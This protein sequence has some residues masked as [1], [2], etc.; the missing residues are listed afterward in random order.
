MTSPQQAKVPGVFTLNPNR[1]LTKTPGVFAIKPNRPLTTTERYTL[2]H[3]RLSDKFKCYVGVYV[4]NQ[5]VAA[6][7]DSGNTS[8]SCMNSDFAKTLGIPAD[9]IHEPIIPSVRIANND[10][11]ICEGITILHIVLSYQHGLA[12]V[13]PVLILK[14][15][16]HDLNIGGV[17][18][19]EHN[20]DLIYTEGVMRVNKYWKI[21]LHN[22][23]DLGRP[24]KKQVSRKPSHKN[25]AIVSKGHQKLA[26]RSVNVIEAKAI[27][28]ED[29]HQYTDQFIPNAKFEISEFFI[30]QH[31]NAN[32][33]HWAA[34]E[35]MD[36]RVPPSVSIRTDNEVD[37]F[38]TNPYQHDIYISDNAHMGSA[39][40]IERQQ[41][42]K[43]SH[44]S[45]SK[46]LSHVKQI[47]NT[48]RNNIQ[49]AVNTI[50]PHAKQNKQTEQ[51]RKPKEKQI[52][53]VTGKKP[54][55]FHQQ[56]GTMEEQLKA[57]YGTEVIGNKPNAEL[58]VDTANK[59][60]K[61]VVELFNFKDSK[62]LSTDKDVR[63]QVAKLCYHYW[64]IH[65]RDGNLG[66]TN[67]VTY[68]IN[69]PRNVAPIRLKS[70]PVNPNMQDAL[71][72]QIQKWLQ[73]DVICACSS[74]PWNSPLLP[75]VKK[76]GSIRYALDF[77]QLNKITKKS[78]FPLP[79]IEEILS[80]LY[81]SKI[82]S[83]I[84]LS[85]A[86]HAIPIR[87][88]DQEKT[89]FT[90]NDK[91]YKFKRLPFGLCNSPSIYSELMTIV[92]KPF[93]K[94]E[95]VHFMDDILVYSKTVTE[96]IAT[97]KRLF[98]AF[99][100]AGMRIT[101]QKTELLRSEV[102]YLGHMIGK[103]GMKI[104]KYYTDIITTW[105]LPQ[106]LKQL[107]MFMGKIG[108]YRKFIDSFSK[109]ASPL[110]DHMKITNEGK[111][112]LGLQND[113]KAVSSFNQLK[114]A[115]ANATTLTIPD[116]SPGTQFILDT[117]FSSLGISCVLSQKQ[118]PEK[119]ERPIAFA[120]KRLLANE[121][122]YS[123]T[124]GELLAL[125]Y[126]VK[127]FKFYLTCSKFLWRTDNTSLTHI[128]TMQP[129]ANLEARWLE[130][131]ASFD[132]EI[133][134]RKGTQHTN[135]DVLSRIEHSPFLTEKESKDLHTAPGLYAIKKKKKTKT[136][137]VTFRPPLT[138][139]DLLLQ[140][141]DQSRNSIATRVKLARRA[142]TAERETADQ[143]DSSTTSEEQSLP[144]VEQHSSNEA[145]LNV[146]DLK[147]NDATVQH[148]ARL[149]PVHDSSSTDS[150]D[151]KEEEGIDELLKSKETITA[152]QKSPRLV[153]MLYAQQNDDELQQVR[154]W[155][156]LKTRPQGALLKLFSRNLK[157]YANIYE[158]LQID[159]N[160][161]LCKRDPDYN[162][163][164]ICVPENL[165][166]QIIEDIHN[167]AHIGETATIWAV[168]SRYYF[169]A[170]TVKV[171][172][173]VTTCLRCQRKKKKKGTQRH[174]YEVDAYTV[175]FTSV[176]IDHVGPL[177]ATPEGLRFL[178]VVLDRATRWVEAY[179]VKDLSALTTAKTLIDHYF[180]RFGFP[181]IVHSDNSK[182]FVGQVF[183]EAMR[184]L[185]IKTTTTPVYNPCSN[186]VERANG[187]LGCKLKA[188]VHETNKNWLE[189]LP[190]ALLAIRSSVNRSTGFSPF[191]L[192]FGQRMTLPIDIAYSAAPSTFYGTR[193]AVR[194]LLETYQKMYKIVREKLLLQ[195]ERSQEDYNFSEDALHVGTLVWLFT[196][197]GDP[198]FGRKL[199]NYWAGPFSITA[200]V[201]Q[202]LYK[203]KTYGNWSTEELETTVAADRLRICHV[204]DEFL[205]EGRP[206]ALTINDI[207]PYNE[208]D[209][210]L[211]MIPIS[212]LAPHIRWDDP[213]LMN[214]ND[215]MQHYV[216]SNAGNTANTTHYANDRQ[217][218]IYPSR[219][220]HSK[221]A[222][223]PLISKNEENN[224]SYTQSYNYPQNQDQNDDG[225][226][227]KTEA[228]GNDNT[229]LI[230]N[231]NPADTAIVQRPSKI[232]TMVNASQ[233]LPPKYSS[234]R[235][236]N[237]S[238]NDVHDNTPQA[239]QKPA[240]P[241]PKPAVQQTKPAVPQPKPN[242]TGANK[243]PIT[244]ENV[245]RRKSDLKPPVRFTY[246]ADH[247]A[248]Q[249]RKG[250]TGKQKGIL[251][252]AAKEQTTTKDSTS[253]D[254]PAANAQTTNNEQTA[255]QPAQSQDTSQ[256]HDDTLGRKE[257][258]LKAM[259]AN[260]EQQ[261]NI[262][263]SMAQM[264]NIQEAVSQIPQVHV[265]E[266]GH[267]PP[268]GSRGGQSQSNLPV[269]NTQQ[270]DGARAMDPNITAATAKRKQQRKCGRCTINFTCRNCCEKCN[271]QRKQYC[272]THCMSGCTDRNTCRKHR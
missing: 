192:L 14:G 148:T 22:K 260:M 86:F 271:V 76:N 186:P 215:S 232:Q 101:P 136:K 29:P 155:V 120:S 156:K 234:P 38:I 138:N 207:I 229:F 62:I 253:E 61:Y 182:S 27:S 119:L 235:H 231:N 100:R 118:G 40:V 21:K 165:Q 83:S 162:V 256:N 103:S 87:D 96:H 3:D 262:G 74:S 151:E 246:E 50:A 171:K 8:F 95:A 55:E 36:V 1:P 149:V 198:K 108:Y 12:I 81:G 124:R 10:E 228:I 93:S 7:I 146:N 240:V 233:F 111:K 259:M 203:I 191:M 147:G 250:T 257:K 249:K 117:D 53:Q 54:I 166:D 19:W 224:Y 176:S 142:K 121:A 152:V 217:S 66:K 266:E 24:N 32:R 78:A 97:L 49:N 221:P 141:N 69:T 139:T 210:S 208:E 23:I 82:F 135:A 164:K 26:A 272:K 115:L 140:Q 99:R 31:F 154:K 188:L 125:V 245:L 123:S 79:Q 145:S 102:L 269:N 68:E 200:K 225:N 107:R 9:E 65:G 219:Q 209:S 180:C 172:L 175:K 52:L 57:Q 92:M 169:P 216:N 109:I 44:N 33:N 51:L 116:F 67:L 195:I 58:S 30:N 196:P 48:R 168:A 163:L 185:R 91:Q 122:K 187:N 47:V 80:H 243:H 159:T 248:K 35:L 89:A 242:L 45:T 43:L 167:I 129:P 137:D 144:D 34:D 13:T 16:I 28:N 71:N 113:A 244:R 190:A 110:Y 18:L 39:N 25:F 247:I 227:D 213:S 150:E 194:N 268:V 197:R 160:N 46:Q 143:S 161:I 184:L 173:I 270:P 255:Q 64:D 73:E 130:T 199:A 193:P 114:Q 75:I 177:P 211:G 77:R 230:A 214:P 112:D 212:K 56:R 263:E 133:V 261:F 134:H 88:Q 251:K 189:C 236:Q 265:T 42:L 17:T 105:P 85:Q 170:I 205:N 174:T 179:P 226:E 127:Q 84:D 2:R 20:I 264:K 104:P 41:P 157:A 218:A 131:L 204:R 59:R 252:N 241:Q 183:K 4:R 258:N 220:E 126:G 63:D 201:A 15:L 72:K 94:K 98:A 202:N 70:R 239:P 237:Q 267:I 206:V 158:L 181:Q 90:A 223:V 60:K 222:V 6:F 238:V 11:L 5:R 37:V 106:T 128:R 178:L 153:E 132:F 254:P